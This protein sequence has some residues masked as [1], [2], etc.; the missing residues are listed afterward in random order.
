MGGIDQTNFT[1][2]QKNRLVQQLFLKHTG[3][4]RS[5]IIGLYPN[6][7]QADDI[8]HEVFLTVSEKSDQYRPGTNFI[9]WA[10]SVARLKVLEHWRKNKKGEVLLSEDAVQA[11]A[12]EADIFDDTWDSRRKVLD[13]CLENIVSKAR[14]ILDMRY[15]DGKSPKDIARQME[16]TEGAV[17]V[18]LS[19]T[20]K[21][22][23]ECTQNKLKGV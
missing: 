21:L 14:Q 20:R 19:R 11:V 17:N 3:L 10:R 2:E 9:A 1:S 15:V 23:R 16:W 8:L 13:E 6:F 4:I 18:T 7:S 22:L 12:D 5:F